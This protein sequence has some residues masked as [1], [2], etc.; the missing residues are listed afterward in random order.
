[1]SL[2]PLI[3]EH[4]GAQQIDSM[5]TPF[6]F[7]RV[8]AITPSSAVVE[9]RMAEPNDEGGLI[10]LNLRTRVERSLS[11]PPIQKL[12]LKSDTPDTT[13]ELVIGEVDRM[14]EE[15]DVAVSVPGTV[16]VEGIVAADSPVGTVAALGNPVLGGMMHPLPLL[17][18]YESKPLYTYDGEELLVGHKDNGFGFLP[19]PGF[20]VDVAN[21]G[22]AVVYVR[23]PGG[24]APLIANDAYDLPFPIFDKNGAVL[25]GIPAGAVDSGPYYIP[26]V[27]MLT[28]KLVS[29]DASWS[30]DV[31]LSPIA[32]VPPVQ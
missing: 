9:M 12:F 22:T 2:K 30:F 15:D 23:V 13:V 32:F 19:N 11:A 1:M 26:T 8:S 14:I 20:E 31:R 3:V 16:E 4:V 25:S 7:L 17:P 6:R 21:I 27:G 24:A 18:G 28:L 29:A 5:T 10:P